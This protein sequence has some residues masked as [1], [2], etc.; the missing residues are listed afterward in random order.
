MKENQNPG[1]N[2]KVVLCKC[3]KSKGFF[4]IR[5][6]ERKNDWVRTWAFKINEDKAKQE[7]FE[8]TKISGSMVPTPEYPGCPYCGAI[9]IAQCSCG[10]LFC[11]PGE[12]NM[13]VCP[14]C[15]QKGEYQTTKLIEFEGGVI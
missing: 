8:K 9:G 6:E 14:W 2:A 10:R 15:G 7:G 1:I 3:R 12:S 13:A 4:G 11:G 5:I